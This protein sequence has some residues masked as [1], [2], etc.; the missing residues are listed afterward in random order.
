[1]QGD[2]KL[3]TSSLLPHRVLR[4][5]LSQEV[6]S[7]QFGDGLELV[8]CAGARDFTDIPGRNAASSF[9]R[10]DSTAHDVSH[11]HLHPTSD[12]SPNSPNE[13]A[14]MTKRVHTPLKPFAKAPG[15]LQNS[16]PM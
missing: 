13:K 7:E 9:L 12:Q 8:S 4:S 11:L 3:D 15:D 6:L 2:I 16:P 14:A 1:M 10:A 5:S